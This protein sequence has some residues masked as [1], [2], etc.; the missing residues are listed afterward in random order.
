MAIRRTATKPVAALTA[1]LVLLGVSATAPSPS[2]AV[3][4][5]EISSAPDIIWD[6]TTPDPSVRH[7]GPI[8]ALVRDLVEYDGMMYV[9]GRFLDVLAPDGTTYSQPHLARFDLETGVWDDTFRP[10]VD[11]TVYAMEIT[12]DGR[13]YV[14]GELTGGVALYDARTGVRN[15]T[16]TPGIVN[17]WA[18]PPCSTSRSSATSCTPAA[19]S[20]THRAPHWSTLPVSTPRPVCST[21]AG[22]PPRTSTP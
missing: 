8:A 16:F 12:A 4:G 7:T 14:G 15:T 19:P 10:V 5:S 9:A 3:L 6:V 20:R 22:S 17:S 11:G 18:H 13:L 2:G 1:L 21:P